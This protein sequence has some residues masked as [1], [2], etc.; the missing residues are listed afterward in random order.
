MKRTLFIILM[1][2][3]A[4]TIGAQQ[5]SSSGYQ[6]CTDKY[7]SAESAYQAGLFTDCIRTLEGMLDSCDLLRKQKERTLQMLA[8]AYIE[9]GETGKAESTVNVLMKNYP[10]YELK[11]EENPELYN[12]LIKKYQIHPMLIIGVKNT[13]DWL[14]HK[15]MKT[16]SVLDGLDYSKPFADKGYFFTYYGSAEYEF[17][18]GLSINIDGMFFYSSWD[19]YFWKDPGFELIYWES[20]K[21]I[22]FPL[23]LKKYFY[24]G[25]NFL[26]YVSAGYGVFYNYWSRGNV[27][28]VYTKDDVI[29]GRNADFDGHLYDFDMLPLHNKVNGQWNA[30]AG[31]GYSLKN[32]RFFVDV[33]YLGLTG[34]I[35]APE[36]SDLF[37]ELKNDYFYIDQ[38]MKIDQFEVGL[39]ISYTLFNSV[40]RMKMPQKK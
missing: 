39:T 22:E 30:G 33:R 16:Y 6:D 8:K 10:H 17:I 15:T 12:R 9:T 31:I 40:K 37:P 24:P 3:G 21:F 20:D 19:R 13:G 38:E 5:S 28:L 26:L 1:L 18:R 25:K 27:S 11:E 35:T 7:R 29:T 32:L 2:A 4:L 36:K 23:Y 34:S 14:R